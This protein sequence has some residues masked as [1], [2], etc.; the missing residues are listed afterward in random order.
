MFGTSNNNNGDIHRRRD[1]F[2]EP[3][4]SRDD[5]WVSINPNDQGSLD[6]ES[7][8]ILRVLL[9][10]ILGEIRG[11]N[12]KFGLEH[13][14]DPE[15]DPEKKRRWLTP[16]EAA[17]PCCSFWVTEVF[18]RCLKGLYKV[19]ERLKRPLNGLKG[20]RSPFNGFSKAFK[21]PFKGL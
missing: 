20:L 5:P 14:E 12:V 19:F 18:K 15:K 7:N 2:P 10:L 17:T 21:R 8:L 4:R 11:Y 13:P 6:R 16:K 3:K 1:R 9:L